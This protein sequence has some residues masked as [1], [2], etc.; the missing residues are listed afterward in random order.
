MPRTSS[1]L[2]RHRAEQRRFIFDGRHAQHE[3]V[4]RKD[5]FDAVHT[6]PQLDCIVDLLKN[7]KRYRDVGA[8][9]GGGAV[10][11]GPAGTGKTMMA[12]YVA[13]E[14]EARFIEEDQFPITLKDK[15]GVWLPCDIHNCFSFSEEW[16]QKNNRPVVLFFDQFDD[17]LNTNSNVMRQLEIELDGFSGRCEGVYLIVTSKKSPDEFGK[18]LFRSGRIDR[19]TAFSLPDRRQQIEL[20]SGFLSRYAH[21]QNIDVGNLIYLLDDPS[22]ADLKVLVDKAYTSIVREK[23]VARA[24]G[25]KK[26]IS[27][28]TVITEEKLIEVSLAKVLDPHTG[29]SMSTGEEERT[30]IHEMGHYIV[31]RALGM[32]AHFVSCRPGILSLGMTFWGD[33]GLERKVPTISEKV[34]EIATLVGSLEV[35]DLFGFPPDLGSAT[36]IN[37][38]TLMAR[39]LLASGIGPRSQI[40]KEYGILDFT[41][42]EKG[43]DDGEFTLISDDLRYRSEKDIVALLNKQR[44]VARRVVNFFGRSPFAKLAEM[45]VKKPN[46]VM[47]QKELDTLLE[48]KLSEFKKKHRIVE[49]R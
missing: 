9:F 4:K 29:H 48:P 2:R 32:P 36:D 43:D 11:Y 6:L 30:A 21:D 25:K 12:R 44:L 13:T 37:I 38:A 42:S 40:M 35:E 3:L 47:L 5:I 16:A 26:R 28:R 7:F 41:D 19:K 39:K 49:I 1:S 34:K 23:E 31:A 17:W 10:F 20:I 15:A 14:S 33:N 27:D 46:K 18:S 22:H 24:S 8:R 45:L